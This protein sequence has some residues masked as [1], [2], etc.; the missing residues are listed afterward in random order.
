MRRIFIAAHPTEA[1]MIR[2]LLEYEGIEAIV[3][4]EALF[5]AR[6]LTPLTPDTLPSVWVIDPADAERALALIEA[7]RSGRS[8]GS[9]DRAWRCPA[10]NEFVG[11]EFVVCWQ[12]GLADPAALQARRA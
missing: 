5:G 11:P 10:C 3:R 2:G 1:H 8:S 6:G 7:P 12:C 9:R 4:G